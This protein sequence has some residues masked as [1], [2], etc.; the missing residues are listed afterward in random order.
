MELAELTEL[1]TAIEGAP[2]EPGPIAPGLIGYNTNAGY[3]CSR[4]AGRIMARGCS[5]LFK[6]AIPHWAD[7]SQLGGVCALCNRQP[8]N[9]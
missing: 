7:R 6:T 5:H 1:K 4:C 2:V 8:I 3:V 9:H